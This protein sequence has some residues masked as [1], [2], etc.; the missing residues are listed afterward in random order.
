MNC[1]NEQQ[2]FDFINKELPDSDLRFIE[3]HLQKCSICKDLY[4]EKLEEINSLVTSIH[5]FNKSAIYIP[6]FIFP[7][8]PQFK[9]DYRFKP[10]LIMSIAASIIFIISI[11]ILL[12]STKNTPPFDLELIQMEQD[13]VISDMNE[14]WHNRDLIFTQFDEETG[15]TE[16]FL[17]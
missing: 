14:S 2:I 5:D 17:N 11:S 9:R 4:E 7:K 12:N 10:L 16:V 15:K 13:N 6:E 3:N 8:K 1:Y